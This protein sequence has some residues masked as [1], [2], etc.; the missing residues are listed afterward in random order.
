MSFVRESKILSGSK[1][2]EMNVTN[3]YFST[4]KFFD[5]YFCS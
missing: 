4:R 3:E 1:K 5:D 2:R